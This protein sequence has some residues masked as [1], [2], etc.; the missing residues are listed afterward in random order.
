[1]MRR[2][3]IVDAILIRVY[4]YSTCDR[5]RDAGAERL[6]FAICICAEKD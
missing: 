5:I 4:K 6:S 2:I 3:A 1:M